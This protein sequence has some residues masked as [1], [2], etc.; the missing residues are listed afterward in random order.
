MQAKVIFIGQAQES[1]SKMHL[2]IDNI[3]TSQNHPNIYGKY[4]IFWAPVTRSSNV[5]EGCVNVVATPIEWNYSYSYNY[6]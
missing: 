1:V 3:S 5:L 2:N 4:S 6:I